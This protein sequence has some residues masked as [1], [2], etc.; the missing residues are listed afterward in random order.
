VEESLGTWVAEVAGTDLYTVTVSLSNGQ[1]VTEYFCDCPYDGKLCKHVVA[2]LYYLRD[3]VKKTAGE[4]K[5]KASK[6]KFEDLL[7]KITIGEFKSFINQYALKN[8]DFKIAF[9]IFF[10]DK[11]DSINIGEK[12][13]GIIK[14][15]VKQFS[16]HGFIDRRSSTGL[17]K[18]V[19]KLIGDAHNLL[20]KNN[21]TDAFSIACSVVKEMM[22]VITHCDDSNGSIGDIFFSAIALIGKI[23]DL[24]VVDMQENIFKFLQAQ[25]KDR[26]YFEYGNFGYELFSIFKQLAVTLNKRVEFL[27]FI[28]ARLPELTG[29]Y[30][31]YQRD[32]FNSEKIS[33]LQETGAT[34]EAEKLVAQNMD[35]VEIR[36]AEAL[37]LIDKKDYKNAKILIAGGIELAEKNRH[38]GTVANWEKELLHIAVLENDIA[39]VRQYLKKFAFDRG[40]NKQYYQQLKKTYA[41]AEWHEI[42]EQII[43]ETTNKITN[44]Y[45]NRKWQGVST[46][47]LYALA[48]LYIEEQ[49]LDKLLALVKNERQLDTI[50]SYHHSLL[51]Q[52]PAELLQLYLPALERD[53]DVGSNRDHYAALVA[54]MKQII[55]DIPG[56]Q[57]EVLTVAMRL[58]VKYIR[59][60]AMVDELNKLW[61]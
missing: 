6:N 58:K 1:A 23:A 8:K 60:P 5:R 4:P 39:T 9:E 20:N 48:P 37:K 26:V 19:D 54:K 27:G 51:A 2:V 16:S 59:R 35:I 30:D 28:D 57:A 52:Y 21:P 11:D 41:R 18:E 3:K 47:L 45:S 53:G 14:K 55:K 10:A 22:Q 50:M 31:N 17:S 33:F 61:K 32:Y 49:Y 43:N 44:E 34:A 12:Y 29:R 46:Q 56:G 25:L 24:A 40:F 38:P 36:H 13:N 15:L 42:I 7:S